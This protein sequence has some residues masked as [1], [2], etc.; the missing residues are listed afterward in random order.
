MN[1]TEVQDQMAA[2]VTQDVPPEMSRDIWE[3]IRTCEMC[4]DWYEEVLE[5]A[6]LWEDDTPVPNLDLATPVLR[7]LASR[8]P[9]RKTR[10]NLSIRTALMHYGVAAS[11][12]VALFHFGVFQRLGTLDA[13]SVRLSHGIHSILQW[14]SNYSF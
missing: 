5:L 7:R 10:W 1:C 4:R 3:H 6:V 11:I 14:F 2:Y 13:H 8:T 12:T 9:C